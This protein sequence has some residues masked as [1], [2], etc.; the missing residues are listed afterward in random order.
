MMGR[1]VEVNMRVKSWWAY[2][3]LR[4]LVGV[5]LVVSGAPIRSWRRKSTLGK[6]AEGLP[7]LREKP[8]YCDPESK[9]VH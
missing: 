2:F 6:R 9:F 5:A 4:G 8:I 3:L 7:I 1:G